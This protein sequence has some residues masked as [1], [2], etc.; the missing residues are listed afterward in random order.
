MESLYTRAGYTIRRWKGGKRALKSADCSC[1]P[2]GNPRLEFCGRLSRGTIIHGMRR[3]NSLILLVFLGASAGC[4]QPVARAGSQG[5]LRWIGGAEAPTA[6]TDLLA[7][8]THNSGLMVDIRV[9]LLDIQPQDQYQLR[10]RL[11]DNRTFYQNPLVIELTSAGATH[12][13]GGPDGKPGIWP[14]VVQDYEMDTITVSLN[15]F[16]LGDHYRIDVTT[17]TAG[18]RTPADETG[19]IRSD[20]APPEMRAPALLAFWDVLAADTP[21]QALRSWDGAHTGPLGGRDGLRYVLDASKK[22]KIPVAL[23]DL[24]TPGRLAAL[25][26][27]GQMDLISYMSEQGLLILPQAA[28]SEPAD[29][30]LEFSRMAAEGFELRTSPFVYDASGLYQAGF[31]GQF[32]ALPDA[33][34]LA[35]SGGE[36]LFPLTFAASMGATEEGPS[37]EVRRALVK[38][39][40]SSDPADLVVLGGSLPQSTWGQADMV[41][42]TFQWLAGHSWIRL[43]NA[44]DLMAFP[45]DDNFDM[46]KSPAPENSPLLQALRS[47]PNNAAAQLAWQDYLM[48]NAP[49]GDPQLNALKLNYSGQVEGLLEAARW[50]E[51]PSTKADCPAEMGEG[52]PAEC[53]LSNHEYFAVLDPAG[54]RLTTLFTLD[55]GGPHQLI[56]PTSQFAVG[57]SDP[58]EWHLERGLAADPNVTAGAFA[59]PKDPWAPYTPTTESGSITFVN[60]DGSRTKTYRLTE[61]GLEVDY[62]LTG[63]ETTSIPLAVD[64]QAFY[65]RPTS[66]RAAIGAHSWTWGLA[67]GVKVEV[68]TEAHIAAQG[69]ISSFPFLFMPEDPDL[70]YP[71]GHYLP[72]PLSVVKVEG[73]GDFRVELA[74]K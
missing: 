55:A 3:W 32:M 68:R 39:M 14:R 40:L 34:H 19:N 47:A 11:W 53:I 69:Y 2:G 57:L 73:E 20:G 10:L 17:Y 37:L 51:S 54:A 67:D 50:A 61:G 29:M 44:N 58:S 45:A 23:L 42:P 46:P 74:V 52:D 5:D 56:G 18:S 22:Y 49:T 31:A 66:Y 71:R 7:V 8:Y 30:S 48:L 70:A 25:E 4:V 38:A 41:L 35:V 60:A 72:F 33:T 27:L 28:Y 9:D 21:A 15:R 64:P 36:R 12:T 24:K 59:D 62:H 16:L 1:F 6:A 63:P 26:Y 13:S 43:L 65:S